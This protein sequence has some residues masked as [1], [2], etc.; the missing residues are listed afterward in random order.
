MLNHKIIFAGYWFGF[1]KIKT[2]QILTTPDANV[3]ATVF[4]FTPVDIENIVKDNNPGLALLTKLEQKGKISKTNIDELVLAM[5]NVDMK[6]Q[7]A[8]IRDCF[9]NQPKVEESEA[10]G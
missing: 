7:A 4:G 9:S 10:H 8:T 5:E 2:S 1:F 3:L 6:A